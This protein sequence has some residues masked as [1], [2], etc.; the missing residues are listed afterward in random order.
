MS[1][2]GANIVPFSGA[3]NAADET[4]RRQ[5]QS[6]LAEAIEGGDDHG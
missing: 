2:D 1:D 3:R 6:E 5:A 4:A